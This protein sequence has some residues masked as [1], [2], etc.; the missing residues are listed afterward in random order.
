MFAAKNS[1]TAE[2]VSPQAMQKLIQYDWPGNVRELM[3]VIE[4]AV[5]LSR[6]KII[7]E[8]EL[9]LM[10]TGSLAAE[11]NNMQIPKEICCLRNWKKKEF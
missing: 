8:D 10:T 3:N 6:K 2:R 9:L 4:R 1:K 7:D 11:E 5:V